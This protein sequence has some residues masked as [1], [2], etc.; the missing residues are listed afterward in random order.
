MTERGAR[1][2]RADARHPRSQASVERHPQSRLHAA[3]LV[4]LG[5]SGARR[6]QR[7][8]SAASVVRTKREDARSSMK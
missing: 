5:Q 3:P 2:P 1:G 6:V 7:S 8:V 4:K